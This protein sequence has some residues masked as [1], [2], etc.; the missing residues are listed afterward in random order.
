MAAA[1]VMQFLMTD[2]HATSQSHSCI[3]WQKLQ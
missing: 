1:P 2:Y 3:D